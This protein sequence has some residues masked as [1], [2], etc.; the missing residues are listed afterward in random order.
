MRDVVA[1]CRGADPGDHV[2]P[3]PRQRHQE[4]P[5]GRRLDGDHDVA[6][7]LQCEPVHV[8]VVHLNEA[9]GSLLAEPDRLRVVDGV[10]R[11]VLGLRVG[12][13]EWLG[14]ERVVAA[15]PDDTERPVAGEQEHVVQRRDAVDGVGLHARAADGVERVEPGH[16]GTGGGHPPKLRFAGH[17]ELEHVAV[18]PEALAGEASA[19]DRMLAGD[20]ERGRPGRGRRSV[21]PR[22]PSSPPI[23]MSRRSR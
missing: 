5:V 23:V 21:R 13:A 14:L 15:V 11:L 20:V 8:D 12:R 1:G 19:P 2:T 9:A 6:V 16:A 22:S 10:V 7:V 4:L 3:R 17:R 18:A